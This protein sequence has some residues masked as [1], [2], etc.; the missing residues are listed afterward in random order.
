MSKRPSALFQ[1]LAEAQV[2]KATNTSSQFNNDNKKVDKDILSSPTPTN[3]KIKEKEEKEKLIKVTGYL[4]PKQLGMWNDVT[5]EI[6]LRFKKR[7]AKYVDID[8]QVVLREMF[9]TINIDLLEQLLAAKRSNSL[10]SEK[11]NR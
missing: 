8:R 2:E 11:P 5:D 1:S 6:R 9:D 10:T 7:N 4:S 3:G